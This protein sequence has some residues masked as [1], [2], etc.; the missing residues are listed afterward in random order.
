MKREYT[1]PDVN[2]ARGENIHLPATAAETVVTKFVAFANMRIKSVR[3]AVL[4]AGTNTAAGYDL[5]NGTTT[6]GSIVAGTSTAGSALTG[7]IT[8]ANAELAEGDQLDI[9]TKANSATLASAI[10]VEYQLLPDADVL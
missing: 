5:L 7:S 1:H 9:K 6:V 2:I 3:G 10:V 4:T 8:A